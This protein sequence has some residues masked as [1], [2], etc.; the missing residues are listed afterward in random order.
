MKKG[1]NFLMTLEQG[2]KSLQEYTMGIGDALANISDVN[3]EMALYAYKMGLKP[4]YQ[5]VTKL[6]TNKG[7]TT[8]STLMNKA[9]D[10]IEL[11]EDD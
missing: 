4:N 9:N 10:F 8:L 6:Y 11:E 3:V 5:M 7:I 2:N 1:N